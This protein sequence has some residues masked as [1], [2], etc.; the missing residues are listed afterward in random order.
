M[1]SVAKSGCLAEATSRSSALELRTKLLKR[2]S[3]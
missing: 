2:S 1:K 3:E